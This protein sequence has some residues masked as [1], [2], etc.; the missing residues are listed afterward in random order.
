ML[1]TIPSKRKLRR[2]QLKLSHAVV[3]EDVL[4]GKFMSLRA[5]LVTHFTA[6][7]G[8]NVKILYIP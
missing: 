6:G 3:T 5:N 2:K 1:S 8:E 7:L 4:E